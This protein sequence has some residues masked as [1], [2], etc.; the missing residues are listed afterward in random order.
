ME[1]KD[2]KKAFILKL[3]SAAHIQRWN[4][5]LR[6]VDLP[7]LDKQAHKMIIAYLLGKMEERDNEVSWIDIIEGGIFELLQR[8][9]LTDLKPQLYYKLREDE[10]NYR[11]LNEWVYKQLHSIIDPL[12]SEFCDKFKDYFK[13]TDDTSSKKILSAAHF[14]ATRL[15]F[16]II[17][18]ANPSGYEIDDIR[19]RI[20]KRLEEYYDLEGFKELILYSR[21]KDFIALCGELRFQVRWST[22]PRVPKTAVLGHMLIVAILSYMFSCQLNACNSRRINNYFTGLFHDLPEVLT[23]DIASPVKTSIRGLSEIIKKYER[24]EMKKKVYDLLDGDW[25]KDMKMFTKNEFKNL[26]TVGRKVISKNPDE[27]NRNFNSDEYNPRDGWLIKAVDELALFIE[28]YLSC[29]HGITATE[30]ENV[31]IKLK[32]RYS[33]KVLGGINFG[34]LYADFD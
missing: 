10:G 25:K 13:N 34:S 21:Y 26:V 14:Y 12:G 22:T 31:I 24:E 2:I 1:I 9:V 16:N 32:D 6:P 8:I 19:K 7:E 27:I 18:R 30:L 29:K 15:E 17:E 28:A 4:D 5:K 11:K 33:G 20:D 23:R 3:F